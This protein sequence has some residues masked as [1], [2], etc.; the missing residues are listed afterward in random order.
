MSIINRLCLVLICLTFIVF[1]D[2]EILILTPNRYIE[3]INDYAAYKR[4]KGW[5]AKVFTCEDLWQK[6]TANSNDIEGLIKTE[7]FNN[8]IEVAILV[9]DDDDLQSK[10][11]NREYN[12]N[13]DEAVSDYWYGLTG[14]T[15]EV[16]EVII[17][18]FSV[19]NNDE[20]RNMIYKHK[21]YKFFNKTTII[22]HQ[23]NSPNKYEKCC[24][25]I[26]SMNYYNKIPSFFKIYGAHTGVGNVNINQ[27]F[28][29]EDNGIIMYRGHAGETYYGGSWSDLNSA[30]WSSNI[31][32]ITNTQQFPVLLNIACLSGHFD[33]NTCFAEEF[34]RSENGP[35]LCLAGTR[36]TWTLPNDELIKYYYDEIYNKNHLTFGDAYIAASMKQLI[37]EADLSETATEIPYTAADYNRRVYTWF[38]DPTL[39][40]DPELIWEPSPISSFTIF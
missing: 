20:L 35:A 2:Y 17:G 34:T 4:L 11:F 13:G 39:E 25:Q 36:V 19:S 16:P 37:T 31:F 26:A 22:A 24:E 32:Q 18:R 10:R 12:P 15:D 6:S 40:I 7:Y 5:T 14:G 9:G 28:N 29:S 33:G 3:T 21:K 27:Q 30:Y 23:E 8:D 1:A 38:S